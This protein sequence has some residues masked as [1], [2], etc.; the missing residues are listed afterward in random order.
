[1]TQLIINGISY[2]ETSHDKYKCYPQDSSQPL[3]MI[4]GRLVLE[5][6]YTKTII[7]YSYDYMG[8]ILMRKLLSDLRSGQELDVQYLPDDGSGM[9]RANF[10]CTKQPVPAYAFSR[11]GSPFWHNVSFTL[12]GVDGVA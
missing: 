3:T 8:D 11:G 10:L 5:I 2:P 7:E 9:Q 1:M 6:S 12:E 4:S